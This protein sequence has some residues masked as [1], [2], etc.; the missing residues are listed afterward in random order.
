LTVQNGSKRFPLYAP[1]N[2]FN[3]TFNEI[4]QNVQYEGMTKKESVLS[5]IFENSEYLDSNLQRRFGN[6]IEEGIC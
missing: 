5:L 4:V 1:F 3:R 6:Q 2:A